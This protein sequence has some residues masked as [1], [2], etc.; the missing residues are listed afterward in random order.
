MKQRKGCQVAHANK[1]G[2]KV[3]LETMALF[4]PKDLVKEILLDSSSKRLG[5]VNFLTVDMIKI[6][7]DFRLTDFSFFPEV[8]LVLCENVPT[9]FPLSFYCLL[10]FTSNIS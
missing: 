6:Y 7:L 10:S 8:F 9:P 4:F 1:G 3:F 5:S 2:K